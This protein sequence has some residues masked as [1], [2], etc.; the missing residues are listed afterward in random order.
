MKLVVAGEADGSRVKEFFERQ[1]LP[2]AIDFSVQRPGSF[3]DQYKLLSNDHETLL[4]TDETDLVQGVATLVFREGMVLGEKQNWCFATDLRISPTRKAIAQWSQFFLPVLERASRERNCRYV[5]SAVEHHDNPA[6]N[7]L[8]RPTSHARRKLPRYQLANRFRVV[9]LHG[10]VPFAAKP[11][12]SIRLKEV[13]ASDLEPLCAYLRE[14]AKLKPL[15][16]IFTPETFLQE[17]ARWPGLS[18]GDFRIATDSAGRIRGTAALFD[19]RQ[20]Q[21]IVPTAYHG[22]A[23]T[24]HQTL[25]LA[26]YT[27][28]VRP[29]PKPEKPFPVR[30]LTHLACDSAEIFHRLVD[31]AYTRLGSKELLAYIHFRGNWR[32]LPPSSFIATTLPFGLYLI[33]APNA[34]AP[35]WPVPSIRALPPDFEAAWL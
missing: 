18:L 3:F 30:F 14:Q 27:G 33:L 13:S 21:K 34:E 4:L 8:I 10:R 22:F 1:I 16:T 11:L 12:T 28:L 17:I 15:A 29:T 2:G 25:Y 6:Y 5:F 31:D 7:A 26:S 32:T 20:V 24:L 19:G 23:S 35:P 9:V